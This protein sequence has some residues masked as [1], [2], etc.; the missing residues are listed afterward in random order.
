MQEHVNRNV[1]KKMTEKNTELESKALLTFVDLT[2]ESDFESWILYLAQA[3]LTHYAFLVQ[4][5]HCKERKLTLHTLLLQ[6]AS[7]KYTKVNI[8]KNTT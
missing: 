2:A 5:I 6:S 1:I 7:S 3:Y 4:L 8:G